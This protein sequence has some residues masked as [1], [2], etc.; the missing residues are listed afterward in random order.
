MDFER[1][2]SD[3]IKKLQKFKNLEL[4]GEILLKSDEDEKIN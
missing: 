2:R 4:E 3:E 1:P